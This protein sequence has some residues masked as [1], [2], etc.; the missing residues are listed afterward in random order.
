MQILKL[1]SL[2]N[3][4][5]KQ[6]CIFYVYFFCILPKNPDISLLILQINFYCLKVI[7][8]IFLCFNCYR[9]EY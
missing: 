7:M 4:P 9:D 6:S 3:S 1:E 8:N 2:F 5:R